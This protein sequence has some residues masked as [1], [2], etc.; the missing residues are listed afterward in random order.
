[1]RRKTEHRR[2]THFGA[3]HR[4]VLQSFPFSFDGHLLDILPTL[5]V[6]STLFLKPDKVIA[7]KEL[8]EFIIKY[9]INT[10]I[11]TPS[12]LATLENYLIKNIMH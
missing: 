8:A 4:R 9:N 11:L 2:H 6:G 7:G 5:I 12:K 1:M 10:A 3:G